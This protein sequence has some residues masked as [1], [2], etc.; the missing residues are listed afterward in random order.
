MIFCSALLMTGGLN[1]HLEKESLDGMIIR[2]FDLFPINSLRS[3][4]PFKFHTMAQVKG[5][6]TLME[7]NNTPTKHTVLLYNGTKKNKKK[8]EA[9]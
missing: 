3:I 8:A 5:K 4:I 2:S 7:E 6:A 1:N 9:F